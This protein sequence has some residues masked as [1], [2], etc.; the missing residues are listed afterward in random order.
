MHRWDGEVGTRLGIV[1][2]KNSGCELGK[3]VHGVSQARE[4]ELTLRLSNA[5]ISLLSATE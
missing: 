4:N 3:M 1:T 5:A 2:R